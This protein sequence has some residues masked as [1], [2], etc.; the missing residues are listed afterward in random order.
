MS[1]RPVGDIYPTLTYHDAQAGIEWLCRA[2]GFQPRLVVPGENDT[3]MHSE[4]SL[5]G[6]VVMVSSP[7]PETGRVG[8][9][10]AGEM[11]H[12]ICVHVDDPDAHYARAKAAGAEITRE[13]QDE[14]YG[15]RGYVTKDPEGHVWYFGTYRP[16]EWWD[17]KTPEGEKP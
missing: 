2:F 13:L 10:M 15:S 16:G 6:A 17:G 1:Q 3:V 12:G 7:K 5:G 8:P 9:R 14:D 11:C 4:L